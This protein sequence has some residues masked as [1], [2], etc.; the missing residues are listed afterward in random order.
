MR[1]M[2]PLALTLSTLSFLVFAAHYLREGNVL[3]CAM[4]LATAAMLLFRR[5]RWAL[6][7]SQ[8]VL[9]LAAISWGF[10]T[11]VLVRRRLAEGGDATR[12]GVIL[13]AV[14]AVNVAA[15]ILL[16]TRPVLARYTAPFWPAKRA[17]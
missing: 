2:V 15:A 9:V 12:L 13:G 4:V 17:S 7:S 6:R 11:D 1:V 5:H 3:V 8:V 14:I 10:T 16:G